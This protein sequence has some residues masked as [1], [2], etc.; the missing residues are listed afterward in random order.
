MTSK[1]GRGYFPYAASP[2]YTHFA[3]KRGINPTLC[4]IISTVPKIGLSKQLDP[5]PRDSFN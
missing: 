4:G 5:Q 3:K 1:R 2:I